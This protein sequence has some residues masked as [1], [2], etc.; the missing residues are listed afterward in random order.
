MSNDVFGEAIKSYFNGERS[1]EIKVSS[2]TFEDDIIPVE[3]LFR[4]Y[5]EMPEIE[6]KALQLAKGKTL[7]VGAGA[8]SHGLYLQETRKLNVT[9]LD[10]SKGA[11]EICKKRGLKETICQNFF[12]HKESY[13]TLLMLMNGSGIIGSLPNI[14]FFFQHLRTLLKDKGQVLIDS[15]DL[16]YLYENEKGEFWVDLNDGYYGE[17]RYSIQYKDIKSE[18]FDW[19]YIDYNT[20]QNAAHSNGFQCELILEGDH[21]DYLARLSL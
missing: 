2:N 20:L 14:N 4:S 21:Y 6:K 7:D 17:M 19:L 11:I 16:I 12:N 9:S 8:G 10:T 1:V 18:T 13:D 15:S 3:Y 5:N